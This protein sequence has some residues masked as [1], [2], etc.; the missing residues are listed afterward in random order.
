MLFIVINQTTLQYSSGPGLMETHPKKIIFHP[1]TG[2]CIVR[3]SLF[4]LK[5][6]SCNRSES[7]R[8]SSQRVLSLAEEKILC[9]KA[10]E[11]GESVK[12]RLYFSESYCSK[13]K[14]LSESKMQLSSITKSRESVCLDV[15]SDSNNIVTKSC[16][17]LEGD[18]SCDPKSQW[19]KVVTSTRSRFSAKPFFQAPL[20]VL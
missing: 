18:A 11:E 2:L 17:C 8:L 13:W 3:K 14:V 1:S 10:Y 9:L 20:S 4:Q 6:G 5:L 19:F 15:D 12:L 16:K 7:F